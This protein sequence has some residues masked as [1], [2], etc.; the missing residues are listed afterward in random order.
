[1]KRTKIFH[2]YAVCCVALLLAGCS[3]Q[4]EDTGVEPPASDNPVGL[5]ISPLQTRGNSVILRDSIR[6]MGIFG[7]TTDHD[8]VVP[9]ADPASGNLFSSPSL[10]NNQK[11][12]RTFDDTTLSDWEY[13]PIEYWPVNLSMR[14]SFFAY[15]PHSSDFPQGATVSVSTAAIEPYNYT[16]PRITYTLPAGNLDE[17][18][19]PGASAMV[20]LLYSA[21]VLNKNMNST[22]K[23]NDGKVVYDM[24]HALTWLSFLIA[25]VKTDPDSSEEEI[26]KIDWLAFL[27]D[28]LPVTAELN[29]GTGKWSNMTRGQRDYVFT[30]ADSDG[31][32]DEAL[33]VT[34]G[35]V[36][37]IIERNNRLMLLPYDITDEANVTID[38]TFWHKDI[39]Y[40]YY[41]PFPTQRMTAGSALVYVL[42]ISP[43]GIT[44]EFLKGNKI[45]E[46]DDDHGDVDHGVEIH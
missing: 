43:E 16:Y 3:N 14:N 31:T 20:D 35:K 8:V 15:S 6:S 12:T 7:Y 5:D 24:K 32:D 44:L 37:P 17:S 10:L 26:Y 22:D 46:W 4:P 9:G 11:A 42:N 28:A 1:M 29:L 40:Y 19:N 39:Q 45:E 38:I 41:V 25:P 27:S 23:V 34:A 21:P 33:E 13:S 36:T 2:I 18:D 30:L